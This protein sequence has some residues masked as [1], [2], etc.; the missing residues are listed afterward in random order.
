[1]LSIYGITLAFLMGIIWGIYLELK[2]LSIFLIFCFLVT[3]ILLN[4]NLNKVLVLIIICLIGATYANYKVYVYNFKYK[5]EEE[6]NITVTIISNREETEYYYRYNCKS[7]NQDK[8]KLYFKKNDDNLF[9][10][11]DILN[12]NGTFSL[13]EIARNKGGYNYKNYLNSDGFYGTIKISNFSIVSS[14]TK[15]PIYIVQNLMHNNFSKLF[16][17]NQAGI[18][19]GMLIGETSSISEETKLDFK[20]AGITHLLAVSGSNVM[21]IIIFA[22]FIFS[23][24]FGKK[25]SDYFTI[26]FIIIFV[27]IAGASPSVMRAGI[28]A[29]FT[30]VA[31]LILRVNDAISNVFSSAFIILIFNPLAILNVGFIL[32]FTGTIGIITLSKV[33]NNLLSKFIKNEFLCENFS[34]NI[35]AQFLLIPVMLY[36]F[37]SLSLVSIISNIF[38]IPITGLITIVGIIIFFISILS[39]SVAKIPSLILSPIINY[40][41]ILANFFS[42]LDFLNLTFPR[43]PLWMIISFYSLTYINLYEYK[44]KEDN[45]LQ[46]INNKAKKEL[47]EKVKK[48]IYISVIF[49]SGITILK[50]FIPNPYTEL[51]M[52]DVG[53]GDSFLIVTKNKKTILIDGG[54]SEMTDFDVGGKILVPYLLNRGITKIDYIFISH[55]HADHIDGIYSVLNNLKVGEIYVGIQKEN[56]LKFKELIETCNLKGV[57]I[58]TLKANDKLNIDDITFSILYPRSGKDTDENINNLSLVILVSCDGRNILFMGDA[59]TCVEEKL[60]RI[61]KIDILKV[62]HHGSLTSSSENFLKKISPKI[63]L[64]S[65]SKNNSYGHPNLEVLKRLEKTSKVYMTKDCG[66]TNI[67]IYKDGKMN[68]FTFLA[69]TTFK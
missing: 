44:H 3:L 37:N 25:L 18:I 36:F 14:K 69:N 59:E 32:S 49:I 35:A 7:S 45:Y 42:K 60:H 50:N 23:K 48:I 6:M 13:P 62:G 19:S 56:D 63:S 4:E 39:I 38:I 12:I 26:G 61:P 16:S 58:I 8:F 65:V 68:I 46:R 64:I 41:S 66:E 1:M 33:S 55:A 10:I 21:F 52:I 17:E 57:K 9:K 27:F 11:G 43:P 20:N 34:I 29:I 22:N 53:Q 67:K 47:I 2:I 54:G 40:V 15:N 24:L 30:I 51:T 28:M 31:S 5:D